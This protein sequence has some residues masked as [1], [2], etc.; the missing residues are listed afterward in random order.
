[1][2]LGELDSAPSDTV[3]IKKRYSAFFGTR[4]HEYLQEQGTRSVVV[5]GVNTHAC[6]RTTAIDAYQHDYPVYVISDCVGPYDL[7]ER[8]FATTRSGFTFPAQRSTGSSRFDAGRSLRE[9]RCS[10]RGDQRLE[11]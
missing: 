11:G 6:V 10:C 3:V 5:V 8:I 7:A 9:R 2:L 1:M 4:L